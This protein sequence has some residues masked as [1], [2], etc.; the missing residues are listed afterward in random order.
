MQEGRKE[1][2]E[3]L[4]ENLQLLNNKLESN[5]EALKRSQET[6]EKKSEELKKQICLL[7]TSTSSSS[8]QIGDQ[9]SEGRKGRLAP[10]MKRH[11]MVT[12]FDTKKGSNQE[13][14]EEIEEMIGG[15]FEED[16]RQDQ[17][18]NPNLP[19]PEIE[20]V[21][22]VQPVKPA[23]IMDSNFQ[24]MMRIMVAQLNRN[25]EKTDNNFLDFVVH[26]VSVT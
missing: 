25:Q 13:E 11:H 8:L 5:Q 7:Y 18:E 19:E 17:P 1:D 12:R 4:K 10:I 3:F 15:L 20:G 16:P 2:R 22:D 9:C 6:L 14:M 23:Q 24:E 26:D 21:V